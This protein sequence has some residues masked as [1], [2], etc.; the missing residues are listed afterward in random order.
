MK[1]SFLVFIVDTNT[2][3]VSIRRVEGAHFEGV[4]E[5]IRGEY[6]NHPT[7]KAYTVAPERFAEIKRVIN[8]CRY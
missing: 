6:K 2:H 8:E 1:K 4:E 3:S 5:V 7:L